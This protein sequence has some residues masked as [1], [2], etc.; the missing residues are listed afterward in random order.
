MEADLGQFLANLSRKRR[1]PTQKSG[2]EARGTGFG[3]LAWRKGKKT[4]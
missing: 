3:Q 4:G 2:E 1:D